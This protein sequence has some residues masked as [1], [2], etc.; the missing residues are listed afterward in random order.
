MFSVHLMYSVNTVC[1]VF[2]IAFYCIL[3]VLYLQVDIVQA[4]Q[5]LILKSEM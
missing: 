4:K 5:V 1:I 3:L 2:S